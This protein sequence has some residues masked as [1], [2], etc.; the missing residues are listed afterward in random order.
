MRGI[1]IQTK[2]LEFH[3]ETE[4]F[5][6]KVDDLHLTFSRKFAIFKLK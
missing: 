2:T 4:I 6:S 3:K 5:F 1:S